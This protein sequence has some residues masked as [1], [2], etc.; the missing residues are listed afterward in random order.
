MP[1][2]KVTLDISKLNKFPTMYI[3]DVKQIVETFNEKQII[4]KSI[5]ISYQKYN[6]A[7]YKE[8]VLIPEAGVLMNNNKLLIISPYIGTDFPED[9][10][11]TPNDVEVEENGR[12][13]S[14]R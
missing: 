5:Y 12:K 11:F 4:Q 1:D 6:F 2:W 10:D 14:L 9:I 7:N 3:S 13:Y 8:R